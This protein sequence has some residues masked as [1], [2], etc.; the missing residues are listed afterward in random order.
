MFLLTVPRRLLFCGS[1]LF[2]MIRVCHAFVSFHCSLVVTCCKMTNLLAFLNVLFSC[3]FVTFLVWCPGSGVVLVSIPDRCLLSY[4]NGIRKL[5]GDRKYCRVL[6][7]EH[8]AIL[9]AFIKL[10]SVLT[11][12]LSFVVYNLLALVCGV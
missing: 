12:W 2:L 8:S 1:F 5:N 9:L 4:F 6:P 10:Y 3:V 11:S 7:L